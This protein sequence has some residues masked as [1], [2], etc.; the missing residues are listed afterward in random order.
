MLYYSLAMRRMIGSVI[1]YSRLY[2]RIV[3]D[4][5]KSSENIAFSELFVSFGCSLLPLSTR[6][7]EISFLF[8]LSYGLV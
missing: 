1:Y 7:A 2:V 6:D 4:L 3:S 8:A 5:Q